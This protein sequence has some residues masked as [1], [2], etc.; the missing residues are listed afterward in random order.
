MAEKE[1]TAA[2]GPPSAQ[3]LA[4]DGASKKPMCVIV[5]GM[6]G[7]GKTSF[8]QRLT[9]DL[10]A[11]GKPPYV[12]NLDPAC[13]EV[14]YPANVDI[15]DTVN[16]KE[17]MKQYGLGPN[18]ELHQPIDRYWTAKNPFCYSIP[19]DQSKRQTCLSNT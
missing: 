15:R 7:S 9:A 18:G 12:V 17:V 1:S 4:D 10:Y 16:Y 19:T 2:A 3:T 6:A 5:L 14:P 11:K 13:L 8:I